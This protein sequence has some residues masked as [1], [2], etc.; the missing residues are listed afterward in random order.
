M[1]GT[2]G[3]RSRVG[4]GS[5]FSFTL[6]VRTLAGQEPDGLSSE[7][8]DLA[9]VTALVADGN[10]T[11]RALLSDYMTRW[12]MT[13]TATADAGSTLA[14]LRNASRQSRPIAVALVEWPSPGSDGQELVQT[15]LTDPAVDPR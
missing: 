5:T 4:V 1:G 2:L 15:I 13:V 11:E 7:D 10:A 8:P 14:A 6:P 9:G 3:V 12:G